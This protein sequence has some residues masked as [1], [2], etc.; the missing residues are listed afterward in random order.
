[1]RNVLVK[2]SGSEPEMN[3]KR[4]KSNSLNFTHILKDKEVYLLISVMWYK[5]KGIS[6]SFTANNIFNKRENNK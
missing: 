1:M 5:E 6:K 2:I 4:Q 3:E